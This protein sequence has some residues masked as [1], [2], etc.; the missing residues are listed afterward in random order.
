[1]SPFLEFEH[2]MIEDVD[3]GRALFSGSIH[4]WLDDVRTGTVRDSAICCRDDVELVGV[5]FGVGGHERIGATVV[6]G[7]AHAL[8]CIRERFLVIAKMNARMDIVG[9]WGL[10]NGNC[11]G[12][13]GR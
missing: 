1:M 3:H 12:S 4:R 9:E 8:G 11:N 5:P 6:N 7:S 13:H 2:L 10:E